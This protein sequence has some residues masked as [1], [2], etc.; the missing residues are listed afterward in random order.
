[1]KKQRKAEDAYINRMWKTA[2]EFHKF[3]QVSGKERLPRL[4]DRPQMPYTEATILELFR[5]GNVSCFGLPHTTLYEEI[6]LRGKTIPRLVNSWIHKG[7][8]SQT[9]Q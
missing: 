3:P 9:F 5:M 1:M 7:S 6:T 8:G 4:T 2:L